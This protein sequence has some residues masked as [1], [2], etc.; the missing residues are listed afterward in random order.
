MVI[1]FRFTKVKHTNCS[2]NILPLQ[3]EGRK[4]LC[5]ERTK[6]YHQIPGTD[7]VNTRLDDEDR[8]KRHQAH[9]QHRRPR[10]NQGIKRVSSEEW[11]KKRVSPSD[12]KFH[13]ILNFRLRQWQNQEH[14]KHSH[15]ESPETR[16]LNKTN[17]Q[18]FKMVTSCTSSSS[19]NSEYGGDDEYNRG[20]CDVVVPASTASVLRMY[21]PVSREEVGATILPVLLSNERKVNSCKK[22]KRKKNKD[23]TSCSLKSEKFIKAEETKKVQELTEPLTKGNHGYLRA[24]SI[25]PGAPCPF[26]NTPGVTATPFAIVPL[27][28]KQEEP[29]SLVVQR[30]KHVHHHH[31]HY[32]HPES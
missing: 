28:G 1:F 19:S 14:P 29:I 17:K 26:P 18:K 9:K 2:Q 4:K 24:N 10:F 3:S 31:H 12:E 16:D 21:Q 23:K 6:H 20:N 22:T 30:H 7:R 32:Y 27:S 15:Q 13:E 11:S 8:K 25:D 5:D